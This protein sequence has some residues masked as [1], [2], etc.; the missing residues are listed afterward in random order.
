MA[1]SGWLWYFCNRHG[2]CGL[3][4]QGEKFSADTESPEPFKKQLQDVMEGE[5]FALEQVYNYDEMGLYIL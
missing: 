5:G 1:S 2:I 4:L 3:C